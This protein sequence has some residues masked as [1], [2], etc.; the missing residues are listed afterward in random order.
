MSF[1]LNQVFSPSLGS[2][3]VSRLDIKHLKDIED[4][5]DEE[6]TSVI[7]NKNEQETASKEVDEK[8]PKQDSKTAEN[9]DEL[10]KDKDVKTFTNK[11]I[12]EIKQPLTSPTENQQKLYH[13]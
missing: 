4:K 10:S 13:H 6:D 3:S 8:H 12:N 11:N 7:D 2:F 1:L 9:G 5:K